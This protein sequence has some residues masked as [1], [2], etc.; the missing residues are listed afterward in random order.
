MT[1]QKDQETPKLVVGSKGY[2]ILPAWCSIESR[3]GSGVT[4]EV[5]ERIAAEEQKLTA[6]NDAEYKRRVEVVNAFKLESKKWFD[7]DWPSPAG[8]RRATILSNLSPERPPRFILS[9]NLK[10]TK[11]RVAKEAAQKEL[12]RLMEQQ[13][14]AYTMKCI[15]YLVE[16]GY[17]VDSPEMANPTESAESVEF[18]RLC[19]ERIE[20]IKKSGSISFN[21]D[22]NC[23]NC[24]GWDGESRRCDCGN[25]RVSW[26]Y[27]GGIDNMYIYGEAY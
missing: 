13:K 22:D 6:L 7:E 8:K 17:T 9:S 21:G 25:R 15:A 14:N 1:E 23:E 10:G 12:E 4:D 3:N 11:E 2:Y 19:A 20:S 16:K 24:S 5:I 18:E 26:S 27:D